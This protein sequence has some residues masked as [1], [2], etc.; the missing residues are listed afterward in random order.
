MRIF[1]NLHTKISMENWFFTH[2]LSHL[3]GLVSFY[4]LLEH[5]KNFWVGL[6]GVVPPGFGVL[7]IFFLE[8]GCITHWFQ[9]NFG[10][11]FYISHFE[12]LYSPCPVCHL[13]FS[14]IP[15]G[16]KKCRD[17]DLFDLSDKGS[18]R[19]VIELNWYVTWILY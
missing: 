2:F 8:R 14:K 4:T 12:E 13:K 1:S 15:T 9:I 11:V 7:S 19:W 18:L 6:G 5:S 16:S 17:I 3:P 10:S